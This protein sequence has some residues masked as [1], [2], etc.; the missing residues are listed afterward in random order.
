MKHNLENTALA[1]VL[2]QVNRMSSW[3]I[4]GEFRYVGKVDNTLVITEVMNSL[5]GY[6]FSIYEHTSL[7]CVCTFKLGMMDTFKNIRSQVTERQW[8]VLMYLFTPQQDWVRVADY[9][10]EKPDV[11]KIFDYNNLVNPNQ[12]FKWFLRK[13]VD[14]FKQ[15]AESYTA[16]FDDEVLD[17]TQP[18]DSNIAMKLRSIAGNQKVSHNKEVT[19]TLLYVRPKYVKCAAPA[20]YREYFENIEH[21]LVGRYVAHVLSQFRS[22]VIYL[23]Q[24]PQ[25]GLAYELNLGNGRI[26]LTVEE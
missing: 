10:F 17:Y 3:I 1:T 23:G 7:N 24:L 13:L 20:R 5:R 19:L 8:Q 18:V 26:Y 9:R 4:E 12:N 11:K 14:N 25:G 21:L 2:S 6:T 22:A 16:I 15:R